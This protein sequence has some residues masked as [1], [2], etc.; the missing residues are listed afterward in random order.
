LFGWEYAGADTIESLISKPTLFSGHIAASPYPINE[1]WY[2]KKSRVD[3]LAS[4]FDTGL[5]SHLY[6]SVSKG[7]GS[8]IAGTDKLNTLL[9]KEAPDSLRWK[10]RV[11]QG[12]EHI[13]TAH[14]SLFKGLKH[15]FDGYKVF[16]IEGLEKFKE[17]GGLSNFYAYN[18]NRAQRY[19]FSE[20]NE[21]WSMFTIVRNAIRANNYELFER[22]M[23]EF[24]SSNML[25]KIKLSRS[26]LIAQFYLQNKQAIKAIEI[27]KIMAKFN[28]ENANI[29]HEIGRI[30]LSLK[31]EKQAKVYYQK[32]VEFALLSKDKKLIEYQKDLE[33][34]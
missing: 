1:S 32:A 7:E 15:Y 17:A 14:A 2:G 9:E 16:H 19:G 29:Q 28:P 34:L 26:S 10:Y 31:N 8:V 27:Y 11:I 13:S 6:I 21:P 4:K 20:E 25:E 18:K 3:Q 24:K 12:E 22:F 5:K 33:Q 30:Y 23:N